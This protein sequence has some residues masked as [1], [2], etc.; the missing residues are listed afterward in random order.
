MFAPWTRLGRRGRTGGRRRVHA[1]VTHLAHSPEARSKSPPANHRLRAAG[2]LLCCRL[3]RAS[4]RHYTHTHR[5]HIGRLKNNTDAL[6]GWA[7]GWL[8]CWW[9]WV[10]TCCRNSVIADVLEVFRSGPI[11]A[12]YYGCSEDMRV[13]PTRFC[14]ERLTGSGRSPNAAEFLLNSHRF[15]VLHRPAL[16][17]RPVR[18]WLSLPK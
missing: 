14:A 13:F 16:R 6:V 4:H 5:P 3:A 7:L 18:H 12:G 11:G 9:R 15:A 2:L 1:A 17:R 10:A 8:W